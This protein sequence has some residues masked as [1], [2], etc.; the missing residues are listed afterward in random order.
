[1]QEKL[2]Y[3]CLETFPN[4]HPLSNREVY[5]PNYLLSESEKKFA[6]GIFRR[7]YLVGEEERN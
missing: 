6:S 2:Q 5:L 7:N 1:M 4:I 3:L